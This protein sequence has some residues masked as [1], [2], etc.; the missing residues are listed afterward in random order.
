MAELPVFD[1]GGQAKLSISDKAGKWQTGDQVKT[2]DDLQKRFSR[3]K[4]G[5]THKQV[6]R[7]NARSSQCETAFDGFW[8]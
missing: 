7:F 1:K 6:V 2:D 5:Y 3:K 4:T 8:F